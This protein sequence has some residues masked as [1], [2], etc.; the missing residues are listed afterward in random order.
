MFTNNPPIDT[1]LKE[2]NLI[3]TS[4]IS[5]SLL[6]TTQAIVPISSLES[7][8]QSVGDGLTMITTISV[9]LYFISGCVG[10][11]IWRL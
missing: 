10:K 11:F 5:E 3:D 9:R 7:M 1:A 8:K 4:N 6:S 2:K